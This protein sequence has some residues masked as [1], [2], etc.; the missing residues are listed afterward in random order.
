MQI[1]L[2]AIKSLTA[3]VIVCLLF[4]SGCVV[5]TTRD[6]R[7][8]VTEK[9]IIRATCLTRTYGCGIDPEDD[10]QCS[11]DT[12]NPKNISDAREREI[13]KKAK[14]DFEACIAYYHEELRSHRPRWWPRSLWTIDERYSSAKD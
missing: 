6:V 5:I 2:T 8:S 3:F 4:L 14:N 13:S 10:K 7:P 12:V 11:S 1:N 9:A